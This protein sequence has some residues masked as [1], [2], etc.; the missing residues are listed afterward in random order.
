MP[1]PCQPTIGPGAT[2]DVVRRLQRA[3]RRTPDLGI[4]VDGVFGPQ[5]EAAVKSFQEG[6]GL[7]VDGHV[8]PLTWTPSAMAADYGGRGRRRPD[9]VGLLARS[10]RHTGE[11]SGP[12]FRHRLRLPE[13]I[14]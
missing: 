10:E 11:C 13:R 9:L 8:G 2:G 6:S 1:N 5:L 7:V 12:Q 3:L 14:V 4:S